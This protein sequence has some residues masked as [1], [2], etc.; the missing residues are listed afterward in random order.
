[1][2]SQSV[3][4]DAV[5]KHE[6]FLVLLALFIICVYASTERARVQKWEKNS[7][8]YTNLG[9]TAV[10][11]IGVCILY[12]DDIAFLMILAS[13]ILGT[14]YVNKDFFSNAFATGVLYLFPIYDSGD[15]LALPNGQMYTFER[16]GFMRTTMASSDGK[17]TLV[18]NASLLTDY[19]SVLKK[20]L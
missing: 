15:K 10:F 12:K 14:A 16:L 2:P 5:K 9:L 20:I 17:T 3:L 13:A 1:M 18:P 19:V 7:L 6:S 11:A 8:I 4:I